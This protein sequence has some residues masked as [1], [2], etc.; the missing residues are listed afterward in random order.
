MKS[1]YIVAN[2]YP[3]NSIFLVVI[4]SL[5]IS[6]FVICLVTNM[7]II[8]VI[9][10]FIGFIGSAESYKVLVFNPAYGASHS[11]FLGKLSDI[12]IDG[13][14][15]VTM[16]IPV[17]LANKKN[18]IGSKKVKNIVE[19]G[20]DSR[21]KAIF[22]AG[23][24]EHVVKS[25]IWTMDPE[26]M[27][28]FS[29]IRSM[30]SA[31]SHECE[32]IFQQTEILQK[33]RNE[34][35]DLAITESLFACPFGMFITHS[36]VSMTVFFAAVFDHIGIKTVINAES[37]LF[38][39]AV[40]YAHG[41]P[42]AISY[43]PGLFS[44]INDKMSFFARIQNLIRMIFTHYLTVSRYQGELEAIKP[45]YNKTKSWTEL[46]SGV[47]FYFINSNQYLDYASPN[48]PKTVF[49]G[50]MQVVTNKKSTKLNKHWDSLLSVRKQ[51]VLISFGSN[52]HSCDMPE[53]YKQS[54]LE[55]FASMPETTFIWKYEDEN[56]TLAD[57]LSNVELTKW[58]PQNDLLA[59][60]RL[61]LFVTHG[62]LGSTM[63]LAYQG[64]PALIIPLLADQPRN[65]HMLTRHGGSLQFDKTKLSNSEDLRRAI[66][67][68]LND[69]KYTESAR[70]LA[71][72]LN[73]QPFSPKD[74]VLNHC[75]FAVEH[76]TL[77]TLSSEGKNLNFFQFYSFDIFLGFIALVVIIF[78]V[79]L[80]SLVILMRLLIRV[81]ERIVLYQKKKI[82]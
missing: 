33:L 20:Q 67:E 82:E 56:A 61:T 31:I 9:L 46:I 54:F 17:Y 71:N 21:T 8:Y 70:K 51:N 7:K 60:S 53:E 80:I 25:K 13:G 58:M 16:L 24:I 12:L 73:S 10:L 74:V 36:I 48:L 66:K 43:F 42:A 78:S 18:Q 35:F 2:F 22:E 29:L 39:D 19:I 28:H 72:I 77:E 30:N 37:N 3:N 14:H 75:N 23:N 40:K 57:H 32:F 15:E 5:L 52:A 6:F 63:E 69:K 49:I 47:A 76:G 59:D 55:V 1:L 4:R 68:V 50:G 64:K 45:Y 81:V 26:M 34:S 65:A 38:K 44:P 27:S 11:N 79:T 41:E 62:G